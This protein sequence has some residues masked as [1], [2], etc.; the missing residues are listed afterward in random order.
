M[1]D[2]QAN[3]KDIQWKIDKLCAQH[4]DMF[5]LGYSP[6]FTLSEVYPPKMITCHLHSLQN[7][8]KSSP[9]QKNKK[10]KIKNKIYICQVYLHSP[11]FLVWSKIGKWK[12]SESFVKIE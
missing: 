8:A 11:H 9:R 1:D 3:S 6:H 10:N 12:R 2:L 5:E 7:N 4:A